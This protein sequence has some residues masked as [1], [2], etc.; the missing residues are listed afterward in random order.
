[1]A[2]TP[3]RAARDFLGGPHVIGDTSRHRVLRA[4]A[5]SRAVDRIEFPSTMIAARSVLLKLFILKLCVTAVTTVC[6]SVK[7]VRN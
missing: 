1:M 3:C 6:H 5:V 7:P 2:S 4:A